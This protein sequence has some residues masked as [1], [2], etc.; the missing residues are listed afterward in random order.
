MNRLVKL[1]GLI[2]VT[3]EKHSVIDTIVV[4]NGF[5]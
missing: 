4:I 1:V 3:G 5:T 2:A